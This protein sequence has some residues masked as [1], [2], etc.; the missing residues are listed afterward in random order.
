MLRVTATL[1][2]ATLG[3]SLELLGQHDGFSW[4]AALPGAPTFQYMSVPDPE[5]LNLDGSRYGIAVCLSTVSK[6]N[7]TFSADGGGEP[8]LG[9]RR[10]GWQQSGWGG[11]PRCPRWPCTYQRVVS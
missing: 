3:A 5:A 8:G 4:P 7:W 10:G 9:R 1:A 11:A 2:F 6:A